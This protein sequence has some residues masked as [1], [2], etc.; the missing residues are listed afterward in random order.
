M[1]GTLKEHFYDF[2]IVYH[3]TASFP[4]SPIYYGFRGEY[5][6][7]SKTFSKKLYHTLREIARGSLSQAI[8]IFFVLCRAK[9][10][11]AK[12]G[13]LVPAAALSLGAAVW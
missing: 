6:I 10:P 5:Y 9:Q 7:K 2:F 3:L 1:L 11:Q 12:A 8:K 13:G 4:A